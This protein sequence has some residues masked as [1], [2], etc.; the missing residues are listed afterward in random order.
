MKKIV[1]I[2][3]FRKFRDHGT[4]KTHVIDTAGKVWEELTHG[5]AAL[6]VFPKRPWRSIG[7]A[8]VVELGGLHFHGKGLAMVSTQSGFGIKGIHLGRPTIHIKHDHL[9][10]T[11]RIMRW[12]G[13]EWM[14]KPL[15]GS[16]LSLWIGT[17]QIREGKRTKTMCHPL[18]CLT[19]IEPLGIGATARI[20]SVIG[21]R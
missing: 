6:P 5:H 13:K 20:H 12:F 15:H 10:G 16:W 1:G 8:I 11:W 2:G 3:V 21:D 7:V 14:C 18:E 9:L 4:D 17:Q 19:S